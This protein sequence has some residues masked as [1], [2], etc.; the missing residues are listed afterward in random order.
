MNSCLS[1]PGICPCGESVVQHLRRAYISSR[2]VS[3]LREQSSFT[4][5][6][7]PAPRAV[8]VFQTFVSWVR[9]KPASQAV[10]NSSGT[11]I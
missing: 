1:A 5:L 8:V 2:L 7:L 3:R 6:Q 9:R 10:I 11:I 4:I